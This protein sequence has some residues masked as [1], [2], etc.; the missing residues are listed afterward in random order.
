MESHQTQITDQEEKS[1]NG[2]DIKVQIREDL[3]KGLVLGLG[4]RP[5]IGVILGFVAYRYEVMPLMQTLSHTTR[6][7]IVNSDGL[8]GF[9]VKDV[10]E[11]LKAADASGQLEHCKKR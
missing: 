3:R 6:A 1:T 11:V 4:A 2:F 9:L 8:P 7:Y 5:P 10:F